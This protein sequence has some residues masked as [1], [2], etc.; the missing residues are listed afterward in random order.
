MKTAQ[1]QS[2][3]VYFPCYCMEH[4]VLNLCKSIAPSYPH[5]PLWCVWKPRNRSLYRP[6]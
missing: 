1:K 5:Q 6:F 3:D 2:S 4:L